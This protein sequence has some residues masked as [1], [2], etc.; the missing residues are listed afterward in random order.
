MAQEDSIQ[1]TVQGHARGWLL[2]EVCSV[3]V[4]D[5]AIVVIIDPI[6]RDLATISDAQ[7]RHSGHRQALDHCEVAGRI[8]APEISETSGRPPA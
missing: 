4:V 8:G 7:L 3:H 6:V 5:D 1:R 2:R